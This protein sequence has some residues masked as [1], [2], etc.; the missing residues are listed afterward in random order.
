MG[1]DKIISLII[2]TYN[3]ER[4]LRQCLDS[5]LI[6]ENM[7]GVEVLVINDGSKDASSAIAHEYSGR[8]PNVFR[9]IDKENGNYGSCI[10]RGLKEATGKYVKV[11]DADDSFDT[12]NLKLFIEFLE[13]TDT[14]L[15]LSD[16][17]IVNENGD[18]TKEVS[19]NFRKNAMSMA[20]ACVSERFKNME[21]HAVT[22][23]RT[24]LTESNYHQTE[25]ISYTDQQWIFTPM[26][27]VRTLAIF[28]KP[29]YRYLVGREGQTIDPAVRI[30]KID[31]CTKY[32]LG[33]IQDYIEIYGNVDTEI[34]EYLDAR[35]QPN[36]K[37]IYI[38]Y[39]CNRK[40]I[41]SR[42]IYQFD[43]DFKKTASYLYY[44]FLSRNSDLRIWNALR[45]IGINDRLFCSFFKVLLKVK[46]L[47]HQ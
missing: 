46:T 31:D 21:M 22:Y 9:V 43:S 18:V 17:V 25:G 33:M 40:N 30:N 3:M 7:D 13:Q 11:L 37:D 27:Y 16:F 2:P 6:G 45:S 39:F 41:D 34:K 14:D 36:V 10:N 20:E 35:L 38:T 1:T 44:R 29:V 32:A 12:A 8:Y 28:N 19:Y 4:Y 15:V 26:A 42:I 5:L 24:M 23:R 47:R